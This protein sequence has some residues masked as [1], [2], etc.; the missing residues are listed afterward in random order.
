MY[1]GTNPS[2]LRSQKELANALLQ[3]L[4]MRAL[5]EISV[6][7]I[8]RRAQISRQTFYKLFD[9]KDDVLQFEARRRCT[10]FEEGLR[11]RETLSVEEF[12]RLVFRFFERQADFVRLLL[13]NNLLYVLQEQSDAMLDRVLHDFACRDA[14][15][16]TPANRAFISS[17][18]CGMLVY[19]IRNG[20][21]VDAQAQALARL[22][23]FGPF[24]RVR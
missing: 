15:A 13:D 16:D 20:F 17:G 6:S 18:V 7:E 24:E 4:P 3:L 5:C 8:C 21:D 23:A 9:G 11:R 14:D 2:A 19:Q 1:T 22:L 10:G 12:A